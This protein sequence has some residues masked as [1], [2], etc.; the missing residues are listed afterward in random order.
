MP[1]IF[2][3]NECD[4]GILPNQTYLNGTGPAAALHSDAS[5]DKYDFELSWLPGQKLS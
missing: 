5:R 4:V 3:Y 2:R 1:F